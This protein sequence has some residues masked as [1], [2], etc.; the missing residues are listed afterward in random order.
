MHE[1]DH[2]QPNKRTRERFQ[3]KETIVT[4]SSEKRYMPVA[5][6]AIRSCRSALEKFIRKDPFF[7]VTLDQY[8]S[9]HPDV[10]P[11][12][13][14]MIDA[15]NTLGI[16]PMSAVAGTIASMAVEAMIDAGATYA[17]VDNGGDIA[18][19]NDETVIVGIYA[20]EST[21]NIDIGLEIEPSDSILGICTSSGRIGHSISFGNAD[22]VTILSG[23]VSL[24]DAAATA[25]GNAVNGAA[26]IKEAFS[27]VS[28]LKSI[29]GGLIIIGGQIG[30]Y[31]SVPIV[32]AP[33]RPEYITGAWI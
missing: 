33:Q 14:R 9:A 16:G 19:I 29:T 24:A 6:D 1:T 2:N 12:A 18:L 8:R 11:I 5:K 4:I 21:T 3:L 20:G 13:G 30:I 27:I 28:G 15:A 10:P 23:D 7:A 22:A 17:I 31:G 25:V 26:S 32:E